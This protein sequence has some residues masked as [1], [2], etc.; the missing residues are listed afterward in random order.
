VGENPEITSNGYLS[1]SKYFLVSLIVQELY[2]ELLAIAN[3]K[4]GKLD[5]RVMFFLDE[6]GT[7]PP[8]QSADMMFSAARSRR[9]S[10]VAII[11]SYQQL[12]KNYEHAGCAVICDNCQ[13]TI[14][15]GFAPGSESADRISK[16][17]G[18]RTVMSGTV[19]KGKGNAS[20]QLQMTERPLMSSDELKSMRKGSFIVLKTGAH[21]FISRLKLFFKWGIQFDEADPYATADHAAREVKYADKTKIEAAIIQAYPNIVVPVPEQRPA[22]RPDPSRRKMQPKA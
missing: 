7:I 21:P 10:I 17:M 12:E 6:F 22:P 14:A 11:Q 18:S 9:I 5:K 3:E 13:L 20:Q 4:G 19:T 8:I 15:G 2:G 16:S 1:L